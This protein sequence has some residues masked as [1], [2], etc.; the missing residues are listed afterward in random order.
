[1][2]NRHLI[3][4]STALILIGLS[5][6]FYKWQF[7]GLPVLPGAT[8][9]AWQVELAATFEGLKKPTKVSIFLPVDT[10]TINIAD[11][12]VLAPAYGL[13][14]TS[15]ATNR[16]AVLSRRLAKGLQAVYLR[17]VVHR[18]NKPAKSNQEAE[19][20]PKP[21][22]GKLEGPDLL[23]V[24]EIIQT[25]TST[26]S[27]ET[28]FI[29]EVI[30]AMRGPKYSDSAIELLGKNPSV[31]KKS[32]VVIKI[33]NIADIPSREV[34]GLDLTGTISRAN[35]ISWFEAYTDGNWQPF[36]VET[37]ELTIPKSYMPWWRGPTK[38]VSV[39]GGKNLQ[40]A[41]AFTQLE[42]QILDRFLT[43]GLLKKDSSVIFSLLNL[44]L[45]VQG[46]YRILM[47]IPVGIFLIVVLRN[48]VGITTVGTFMPVLI[49]LAFR[50]TDLVWGLALFISVL[51]I[52][53]LFRF[54]LDQLS[55]VLIPRLA[56]ILIIVV[57]AMAMLSVITNQLGLQRGLSVALFP[58]VILT[59]T[60][61][62]VSVLWDERGAAEALKQATGSLVVAV[63]CYYVITRPTLEY[64]FFTFPELLLIVL[65]L[66]ILLGRYTGYRLTELKRFR[67]F[68]QRQT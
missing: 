46:V 53:L 7:V 31:W 24:K 25:A 26:S 16:R 1:M 5:L 29:Y 63:I 58:M 12:R 52:G 6:F 62:R 19:P 8:A 54:Y 13:T 39:K 68:T 30:K 32:S 59:M 23:A 49:A 43:R 2:Y 28:T 14:I 67:V 21:S 47:V 15:D 11:H 33:L 34:H 57:L 38:L 61:E 50:E 3:I 20:K 48:V 22:P 35:I 45:T 17:F 40:T 44:P 9:K 42:E 60:I 4:L 51:T 65:A 37:E 55:L 18:L 41:V 56:A 66:V 64:L 10:E 36:S 27:D